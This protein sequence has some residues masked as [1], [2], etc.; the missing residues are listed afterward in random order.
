MIKK[1]LC[2]FFPALLWLGVGLF[3][4]GC[5]THDPADSSIPWGRPAAWEDQGP[6]MGF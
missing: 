1:L 3:G 2:A 5:A 6:G 4:P